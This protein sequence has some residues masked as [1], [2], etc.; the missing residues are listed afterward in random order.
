MK[1]RI[2]GTETEF[3]IVVRDGG[4]TDPVSNSIL[5]VGS[6]PLLP[7]THILWDYENENP[8]ND[9]RG[10]EIEGEKERP[11]PE[12]NRMLN[13]LMFNGGRLYVDGAHP[14]FSTPECLTPREVVAYE[15]AGERILDLSRETCNRTHHRENGTILYKNN[16]DGKGNS[17]G[18]HEN[19]LVD[20]NVPF[21]RLLKELVPFLVT[22][23]IF[24]GAGKVGSEN[25]SDSVQYQ[26]SQRADFFEV[27]V[28]LNTMVKRPIMNTRDEPHSDS[29]KYRRL[30][31]IVG[32]SNMS[33]IS[34]YLKVGTMLLVLAVIEE[35]EESG[36]SFENSVRTIKEVSRDLTLKK[37]YKLA[38]GREKTAI[39]IQRVYL[40]KAKRLFENED[41]GFSR[42]CLSKW[43]NVLDQLEEDPKLLSK[44][45]DWLVKK[46]MIETYMERKKCDWNDSRVSLMDLQYHD[47]SPEKGLYY[48]LERS[49]YVNR[50]ITDEEI[51]RA[52]EFPPEGTRAYFRGMCLRK[53]PKEIYAASWTSVLFD[54]GNTTVKKIPLLDPF[55]GTKVL[56]EKI[57][58]SSYSVQELLRQLAS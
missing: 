21:E 37:K 34:T 5:L 10:F 1:S 50:L 26:I 53:F 7:A 42:E 36:I 38:D 41:D 27:L 40:E 8:L 24:T 25:R 9:A 35:S 58:N 33:E 15:K 56:V 29:A 3:G 18:Y 22:R 49:G 4:S 55:R 51:T 46:E 14:E 19:Y 17:Y 48:A 44:E 30:H 39:E 54:L 13:K 32:D 28:D 16:T 52:M 43:E 23:Q 31:V 2:V 12:Y 11:G 20:R 47:I 6:C 45:L 57:L